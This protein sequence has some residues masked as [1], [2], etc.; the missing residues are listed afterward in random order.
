MERKNLGLVMQLSDEQNAL[1]QSLVDLLLTTEGGGAWLSGA[2]Q[3]TLDLLDGPLI[4]QADVL[5][6][7][8]DA[9]ASESWAVFGC[10]LPDL[11][12]SQR[13]ELLFR[14]QSGSARTLWPVPHQSFL[15]ALNK[16]IDSI[17][18]SE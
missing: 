13:Q 9:L 6:R 5:L 18:N 8:I 4:D 11:P 2:R 7:G 14:L 12:P 17:A 15:D 10:A 16:L 3:I 1:L